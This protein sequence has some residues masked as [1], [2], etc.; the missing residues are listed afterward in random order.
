MAA[1]FSTT[2]TCPHPGQTWKTRYQPLLGADLR[3]P[4]Q[5]F[6]NNSSDYP[7]HGD[8]VAVSN[9]VLFSHASR[10]CVCVCTFELSWSVVRCLLLGEQQCPILSLVPQMMCAWTSVNL[11]VS[12]P[13]VL[14]K[15]Q[16]SR[17][18]QQRERYVWKREGGTSTWSALWAGPPLQGGMDVHH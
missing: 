2:E 15:S 12:F 3:S 18:G 6:N 5:L 1:Q 7:D 17:Q 16:Q 14:T 4:V 13:A 10:R 9:E 8:R 11:R